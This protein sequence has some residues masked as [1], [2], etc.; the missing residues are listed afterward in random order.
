MLYG[1]LQH[2]MGTRFDIL[3]IDK[4]RQESEYLWVEIVSELYRLDKMLN[5]F[6]PLSEISL[7]N[8]EASD[9]PIHVTS[10][11]WAILQSC[12]QYYQQTHGL[13]DVTLKDFLKVAFFEPDNSIIFSQSGISL[14]LGGYAKGYALRKIKQCLLNAGVQHCFAD[15]GNSSILG[16][17]HHPHGDAWKV[18]IVNPFN[19][20]ENLGE[21]S[22]RDEALSVSGN[23]PTNT[24]HIVRPDSGQAVK[25]RKVVSITSTDPLEAEILSTAFMMANREEKKRLSENFEIINIIEYSL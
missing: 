2:I 7:I 25:K 22:L 3:I 10:E 4:N 5:R 6:D 9:K 1:S 11:M 23:T 8:R 15:F 24:G 17:G 13:F 16:M 12:R 21:I 20:G 18:S 19:P 14:D